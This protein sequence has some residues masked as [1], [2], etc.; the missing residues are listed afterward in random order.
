M[1]RILTALAAALMAT[2]TALAT[3]TPANALAITAGFMI[4]SGGRWC[5]VS[6]P[7][8]QNPTPG[9]HYPPRQVPKPNG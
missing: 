6:F 5:T 2:I 3:A 1:R 4:T 9:P 8:P 7:D